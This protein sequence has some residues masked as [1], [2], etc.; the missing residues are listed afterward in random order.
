MGIKLA[1]I[2]AIPTRKTGIPI[3]IDKKLISAKVGLR[4][5]A[6]PEVCSNSMT[7][8][9]SI[10][11]IEPETSKIIA[12]FKSLGFNFLLH[13]FFLIPTITMTGLV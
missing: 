11:I 9:D 4:T 13:S 12:I 6:E 3:K 1:I 8:V 2:N 5:N 7:N 10:K